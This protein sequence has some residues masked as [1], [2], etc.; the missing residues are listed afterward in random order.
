MERIILET[1]EKQFS[2]Y[3]SLADRTIQ[4]LSTEQMLHVP[5]HGSN[6]IAVI[7]KHIAGNQL[8]RW[9]DIF[10]TDGEKEWRNRDKEFEMEDITASQIFE[11]WEKG[12]HTLFTTLRSVSDV[13]LQRIIYI[14]NMGHTV[15]EAVIRQLCHYPYHIGQIVYIGKLL[16]GD[17]FASLSIAPGQSAVYNKEKFDK[18][19]GI[20]HFTDDL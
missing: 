8:S 5:H 14:R 17:K 15:Q 18:E 7:M 6:S 9:T 16:L 1:Y 19:K 20:R 13:D 3:K 10:S 12:W 2:Y 4:Q 11:Y